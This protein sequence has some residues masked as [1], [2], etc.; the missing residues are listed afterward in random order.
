MV[1]RLTPLVAVAASA[2]ELFLSKQ[3]TDVPQS[4]SIHVVHKPNDEHSVQAKEVLRVAFCKKFNVMP[5]IVDESA[6]ATS[7]HLSDDLVVSVPMDAFQSVLAFFQQHRVARLNP[8][9][10]VDLDLAVHPNTGSGDDDYALS[11]WAGE[12]HPIDMNAVYRLHGHKLA[13]ATR[14]SDDDLWAYTCS[15]DAGG[16]GVWVD[17]C[18]P[19]A[20]GDYAL[21][22]TCRSEPVGAHLHLYYWSTDE[23]DSKAK[24]VFTELATK[25]FG[26]SPEICHDDYGHEQPHNATC[27]LGGPSK[28]PSAL[29]KPTGGSFVTGHFSIYMINEDVGKVMSWVLQN[30]VASVLGKELDYVL[31][32]VYGC[33]FAD[34]QM[35]SLHKGDVP[36]NLAGIEEEGGWTGSEAPRLDPFGSTVKGA[37]CDCEPEAQEYSLHLLYDPRNATLIAEKDELFQQL[38]Q[39][40]SSVS[41][42]KDTPLS[43][44]DHGSPFLAGQVHMKTETPFQALEWLALHRGS[45]DALLVPHTCCGDLVDYSQHAIWLGRQWPLN[46]EALAIEGGA[47]SA[48][49]GEMKEVLQ[50]DFVLYALYA[51]ANSWQSAAAESFATALAKEFGLQRK[52][53][54]TSKAVEPSYSSLCMMDE[55]TAPSAEEAMA[56]AYVGAYLPQADAARVLSWAM[57]HRGA[58]VNGYQ[59]DLFLAPL[60]ADSQIDFTSRSMRAGTKWPLHEVALR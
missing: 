3:L 49:G 12:H 39:Q 21:N 34:H 45:V 8:P 32:P 52:G 36:N 11:I 37:Q 22:T 14:T 57:T 23:S 60:T 1:A 40:F 6:A 5:C 38:K 46:T 51:S 25:E 28:P 16:E 50:N 33:N 41:L 26:L 10:V 20:Q 43:F 59:V 27:W 54:T 19:A 44:L 18:G 13:A 17:L 15:Y 55:T 53:C 31:H 48:K 24:D 35:W 2:Q 7:L 42:V 58:D 47:V 9:A 56:T 30:N 4:F 29:E